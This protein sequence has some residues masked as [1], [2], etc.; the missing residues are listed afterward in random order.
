MG[1]TIIQS[2][3]QD[4]LANNKGMI[5]K[6]PIDHSAHVK[7]LLKTPSCCSDTTFHL[8]SVYDKIHINVKGVR[9]LRVRV[10]QYKNFNPGNY[11]KLPPDMF[12]NSQNYC[13]RCMGDPKATYC[14][15][16]RSKSM[17]AE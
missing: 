10:E 11:V 4:Y 5:C 6:T 9:S 3:L 2:Q 14:N 13:Q 15:Q 12:A 7:D 16:G 17:R 1:S 8:H